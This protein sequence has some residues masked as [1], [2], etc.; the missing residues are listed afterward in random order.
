MRTQCEDRAV[1]IAHISD[2]YLPRL[3]GIEA[4]VHGLARR[5]LASGHEVT[6]LT[7]TPGARGERHGAVDLVEGVP[8]HRLA[9]RL[10]FGLPVNPFAPRDVRSIL[11][12]GR[13]DVVHVHAG[14]V[15]P[16]AY[17]ALR[18]VLDLGLPMVVTWHCMLGRTER[19]GRWW[20][21]LRD[22]SARP[23]AFTAVSTLAAEP[24]RRVLGDAVEV[25]V[26][27]NGVDVAAWR[28]EPLPRPQVDDVRIVSAMR[29]AR[30]KRPIPLLR[31]LSR[32]REQLSPEVGLR[33]VV[34]GD[35]PARGSM[36]RMVGRLGLQDCVELPG[37]VDRD[38]LRTTYRA[39]DLYVAPARLESFGIA[40][41][42]ARA[43]GLP[44][45]AR[46]DSG[47]REF[48]T[49]GVGGLL[50]PDDRAMIEAITRLATDTALRQRISAYNRANPPLQDWSY[51]VRR[52]DEE[53]ERAARI[54]RSAA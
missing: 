29:L 51:V 46:S 50:A 26:L 8:V 11:L 16:F 36:L 12:S 24:I 49:H 43:A 35:G 20:E 54:V 32:V 3:G 42:E 22:L 21:R 10:P 34:L 18:V 39:A 25:T 13:Y 47:V 40:A 41:L 30:R 44:V 9:I 17:D 19:L 27:P 38:V 14:V 31:M 53:Y 1:R 6:V 37:R 5:Q 33:L 15:S 2:C 45:V 4:Q 52:A 28:T 48:V 23:V 7:A